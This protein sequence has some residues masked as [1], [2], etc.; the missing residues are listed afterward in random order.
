MEYFYIV[1]SMNLNEEIL[2]I[3]FYL[4][5]NSACEILY[6]IFLFEATRQI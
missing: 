2:E 3:F 5:L 1:L 4:Q 6:S